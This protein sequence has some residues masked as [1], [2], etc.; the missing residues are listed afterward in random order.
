MNY[1]NLDP[2]E[3]YSNID[4]VP[5]NR[6]LS[7]FNFN[8]DP[9]WNHLN[10]ELFDNNSFTLASASK[11]N[12]LPKVDIA[13]TENAFL[14][15]AELPGVDDKD[16]DVTLEDETLT[17]KGN[18]KLDKEHN[19][20]DFFSRER[21]YGSFQRSFKVPEIIDQ[22]K[23]DAQFNKGIL[24]VKLPKTPVAKKDIKKIPINH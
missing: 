3:W 18:K 1:K 24:T 4:P 11:K 22:N 19:Q 8:I 5:Y 16:I 10:N 20:S 12:H 7:F 15:F 14:I 23:I 17:L 6:E 9:F 2:V 21:F 13:E